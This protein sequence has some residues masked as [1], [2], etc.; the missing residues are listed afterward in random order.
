[1]DISY[2]IYLAEAQAK[3]FREFQEAHAEMKKLECRV[4]FFSQPYEVH[5]SHSITTGIA[6]M[7]QYQD[8]QS[9]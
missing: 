9:K 4:A 7:K 8:N 6:A 3:R 2:Y 1:M 5:L